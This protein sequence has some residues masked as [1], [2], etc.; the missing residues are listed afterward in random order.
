MNIQPTVSVMLPK[1]NEYENVR[2]IIP[3]ICK[4]FADENITSEIIVLD[5]NPPEIFP[6]NKG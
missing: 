3:N 5:D 1:H 6:W 4:A 2:L